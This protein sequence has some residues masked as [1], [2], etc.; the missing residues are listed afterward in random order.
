LGGGDPALFAGTSRASFKAGRRKRPIALLDPSARDGVYLD[1]GAR[2]KS[3]RIHHLDVDFMTER[4]GHCDG[5]SA[6]CQS[7]SSTNRYVQLALFGERRRHLRQP[8]RF[9]SLD[10]T[11]VAAVFALPLSHEVGPEKIGSATN[12][13]PSLA[14]G[15][16]DDGDDS[17][18]TPPWNEGAIESSARLA[19]TLLP[20]SD[21][22]SK[23]IFAK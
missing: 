5:T 10:E 6:R 11:G 22:F 9:G 1:G 18:Y 13:K 12:W 16:V 4:D 8:K 7:R 14:R 19:H 3:E 20:A 21:G 15:A 23:T 17:A 2:V